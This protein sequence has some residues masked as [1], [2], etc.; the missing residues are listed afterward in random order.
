MSDF[1]SY[2]EGREHSF[3]R[4]VEGAEQELQDELAGGLRTLGWFIAEVM[5][6]KQV[7]ISDL[8]GSGHNVTLDSHNVVRTKGQNFDEEMEVT[9]GFG[10]SHPL[11]VTVGAV[12]N[13][14]ELIMPEWCPDDR[15]RNGREGAIC[16]TMSPQQFSHERGSAGE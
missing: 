16:P 15:G 13:I 2:A 6:V 11:T 8:S 12:P 5:A 9:L 3:C 7:D 10:V 1:S 4:P 14:S